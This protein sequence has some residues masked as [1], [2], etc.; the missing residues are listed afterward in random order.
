MKQWQIL[1]CCL[2]TDLM[3]VEC[4]QFYPLVRVEILQNTIVLFED[5]SFTDT[6]FNRLPSHKIKRALFYF[7]IILGDKH[8]RQAK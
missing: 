7:L 5:Q 1:E 3:I 8:Y 6:G 4:L 2:A